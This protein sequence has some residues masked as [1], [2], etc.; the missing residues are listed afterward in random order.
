MPAPLLFRF[1]GGFDG[2]QAVGLQ[3]LDAVADPFDV[4]LDGHHHVGQHGGAFRPGD[5]EEVREARRRQAQV[6]PD[7]S[8]VLP[9]FLQLHTAFAVDVQAEQ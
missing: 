8:A 9:L 5:H 1:G 6:G 3:V 4:L 2:V 7:L